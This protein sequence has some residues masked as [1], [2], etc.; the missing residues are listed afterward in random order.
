LFSVMPYN[1]VYYFS[2]MQHLVAI[3]D[4]V[5]LIYYD[6]SI[7]ICQKFAYNFTV[8]NDAPIGA[9]FN[10]GS[11]RLML[12]S[13]QTAAHH[14]ELADW[15][16]EFNQWDQLFVGN[17]EFWIMSNIS[18]PTSQIYGYARTRLDVIPDAINDCSKTG[19]IALDGTLYDIKDRTNVHQLTVKNPDIINLDDFRTEMGTYSP[20]I[21]LNGLRVLVNCSQTLRARGGDAKSLAFLEMC[22]TIQ[23]NDPSTARQEW[24]EQ[25]RLLVAI[26]SQKG[27]WNTENV[28]KLILALTTAE[29]NEIV[30]ITSANEYIVFK[31][32]SFRANSNETIKAWKR[33]YSF[34]TL[35]STDQHL[36]PLPSASAVNLNGQANNSKNVNRSKNRNQN[37]QGNKQLNG[38]SNQNAQKNGKKANKRNK[39]Q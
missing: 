4:P 38:S 17:K 9:T 16:P 13:K 12:T 34:R 18:S 19:I 28:S 35:N 26:L 10:S 39:N 5:S 37:G 36:L 3:H 22:K 29:Y 14:Q 15:F 31:L 23:S 1:T 8:A 25:I 2:N 20:E 21:G 6:R 32:S 11:R 24:G 27:A 7:V 33:S 30:L